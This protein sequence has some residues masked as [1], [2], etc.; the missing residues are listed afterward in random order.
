MVCAPKPTS[1]HGKSQK[2]SC[3]FAQNMKSMTTSP[4][5][6]MYINVKWNHD[7]RQQAPGEQTTGEQATDEQATGEQASGEQTTC[8]TGKRRADNL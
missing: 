3:V 2:A 7:I 5:T 1:A 8:A 4:N 6:I